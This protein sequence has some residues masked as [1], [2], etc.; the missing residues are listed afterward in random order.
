MAEVQ[1]TYDTTLAPGYPGMIAN[2]ETSNRISRTC[3]DAGGIPFGVP[4]YRGVGDHGCTVTPA[5]GTFLGISIAHEALGLLAG[6]T[7]DAYP[8]YENVA[9]LTQGVIWVT[10]SEAV[11]D[12]AQ[13]YGTTA[14]LIDDTSTSD[15]I[16]TGW[17]FDT[18][19]SAADL[20]KL[21][22]R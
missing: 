11:T 18:T 20:V 8:Q 4:V 2:G 1:T 7:A 14:G 21:A 22:K 12:G 3:E 9:I 17:F 6:Q 15:T 5:V 13:A 10:A 19:G 16:L